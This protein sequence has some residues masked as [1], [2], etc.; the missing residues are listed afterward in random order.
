MSLGED[1][2]RERGI[3]RLALILLALSLLV[4]GVSAYLRL[5]GAGL[6]C[7]DWPACYG[8]LLVEGPE[9]HGGFA[10]G[11]HRLVA[12]TALVLG[13]VLVWRCLRPR[14]LGEAAFPAV[15]LVA[16][17][18][19]LAAVGIWSNDPHRIAVNFIN[20]LGGLGLVAFSWRTALAAR[21]WRPAAGS[22]ELRL[23]LAALT[24]TVL[25]GALV[26]ARYAA[27]SCGTLPHCHG[28]WWPAA[29]GWAAL[30]PFGMLSG[31]ALPGDAGGTA[32]HLLHRYGALSA[33]LLLGAAA[34][35][36]LGD[37]LRRAAGRAVLILLAV[38]VCLGVVT[39]AAQF[40]LWLAVAHGV[41][42]ALLLAAAVSLAWRCAD[43]VS[44]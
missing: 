16:L 37:P 1:A 9:A 34:A 25:L 12:S 28:A 44:C 24:L 26:G 39:V 32:L 27:A 29:E 23:G 6:G 38:E 11:L 14:L 43:T 40:P 30:D 13:F 31:P 42:A 22:L 3:Q 36:A 7:A 4:V 10:R 17:M 19:F 15:L 33:V 5:A 41:T 20:I 2:R 18:L 21:G 35:R 8:R